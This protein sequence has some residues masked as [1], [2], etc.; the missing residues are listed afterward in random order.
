MGHP[1]TG[2]S[3]C[4]AQWLIE[5]RDARVPGGI[6]QCGTSTQIRMNATVGAFIISSP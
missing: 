3:Y 5:S 6:S 2:A 1:I 4:P